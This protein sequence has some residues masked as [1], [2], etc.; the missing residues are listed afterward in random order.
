MINFYFKRLIVED[1]I[2]CFLLCGFFVGYLSD[3]QKLII[4]S[5]QLTSL[6]RAIGRLSNLTL[7]NIGENNLSSLPEEIGNIHFSLYIHIFS[8]IS[9]V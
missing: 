2:E 5:N 3:L 9:V 8:F 7:L 1:E 6:P 4:Q